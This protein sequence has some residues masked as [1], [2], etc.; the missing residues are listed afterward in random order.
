MG[1]PIDFIVRY[2]LSAA[3]FGGIAT[4][5]WL[6]G[7]LILRRGLTRRDALWAAGVFYLAALIQIT[8]LRLGLTPR[9]WLSGEVHLR[10]GET[11]VSEWQFSHGFFWYHLLGNILWF[12]PFG[13]LLARTMRRPAAWKALLIGA[14]LSA[15]IEATQFLLGTGVCDIDDVLINALG[16]LLGYGLYRLWRNHRRR[17]CHF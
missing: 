8:A 16:T 6:L 15:G 11:S 4:G 5:L 9:R 7:R 12:V 2:A 13:L 10:P 3:L 17:Q 14:A 1:L